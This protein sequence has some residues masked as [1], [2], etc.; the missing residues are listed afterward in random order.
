M[1]RKAGPP[2]WHAAARSENDRQNKNKNNKKWLLIYVCKR[3]LL[4]VQRALV[5]SE[6]K[7]FFLLCYTSKK[8]KIG[9][10]RKKYILSLLLLF[11]VHSH[12]CGAEQLDVYKFQPSNGYYNN[13]K[14]RKA[15][16][17]IPNQKTRN[18]SKKKIQRRRIS[19]LLYMFNNI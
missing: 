18:P 14:R 3:R 10:K 6:K 12:L 16:S 1:R 17:L 4:C 15:K 7:S 19:F 5:L 8:K 13:T 11:I 2:L 9:K